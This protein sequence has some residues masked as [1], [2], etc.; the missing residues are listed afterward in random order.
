MENDGKNIINQASKGKPWLK[1]ILF[2][3]CLPVFIAVS[4][5]ALGCAIFVVR[6]RSGTDDVVRSGEIRK[7]V[8]FG[9]E[10]ATA[11]IQG[12]VIRQMRKAVLK[13]VDVLTAAIR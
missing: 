3:L 6:D 8:V 10:T 13:A 9:E 7:A 11:A 12:Q 1:R 4:S 5:V 2:F